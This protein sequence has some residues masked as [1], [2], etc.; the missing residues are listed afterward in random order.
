MEETAFREQLNRELRKV[1]PEIT[2][3]G[4]RVC[5]RKM[6][7]LTL[8]P[9]VT[10]L[11][12]GQNGE[13]KAAKLCLLGEETDA[14]MLDISSLPGQNV[15]NELERLF[16]QMLV[17]H[18]AKAQ[19]ALQIILHLQLYQEKVFQIPLRQYVE[20]I[21]WFTDRKGRLCY[22]AGE[23]I[24]AFTEDTIV[25]SA[26]LKRYAL[27]EHAQNMSQKQAADR[28]VQLS[29]IGCEALDMAFL[30]EVIALLRPLLEQAKISSCN[31]ILYLYGGPGAGKTT[32]L[33]MATSLY[34]R[35]ESGREIFEIPLSSWRN[36][37]FEALAEVSGTVVTLDDLAGN[38]EL[39]SRNDAEKLRG[40]IMTLGNGVLPLRGG[41]GE[42]IKA[43]FIAAITGN[44]FPDYSE[45]VVGRICIVPVVRGNIPVEEIRR[46]IGSE[47]SPLAGVY[48]QI[49][50]YIVAHQMELV[51]YLSELKQNY[52][53]EAESTATSFW[54]VIGNYQTYRYA[55]EVVKK[56]LR[57][58]GIDSSDID[59]YSRRVDSLIAR[60][61]Q[62]QCK[63]MKKIADNTS[64][65]LPRVPYADYVIRE[66][67]A[68]PDLL[69]K[70]PKEYEKRDAS[71]L[72][73]IDY[74]NQRICLK[75]KR[76]CK[77]FPPNDA[78]MPDGSQERKVTKEFQHCIW[79]IRGEKRTTVH[80][81]GDKRFLA[82]KAESLGLQFGL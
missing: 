60:R 11:Y 57:D 23:Q 29:P 63:I 58:A 1:A 4:S 14:K 50:R 54:R 8:T 77:K 56:F 28:I 25:P 17:L 79:L 49:I 16:P 39:K 36:R 43:D 37:V 33:R 72:G 21:G 3:Q 13:R 20:K 2:I 31:P 9:V 27:P 46:V 78:C 53:K 32:I 52:I 45:E 67:K 40:L 62:V 6:C 10:E 26:A 59:A 68:N 5:C 42:E 18:R 15:I 41:T 19:R 66:L 73:Y 69:A 44:S 81:V 22:C 35:T 55:L 71:C 48:L 38:D 75:I 51:P 61:K 76:L 12:L 74:K 47:P 64:G 30:T 80:G 24:C 34:K 70:S 82:L 65:S 7:V